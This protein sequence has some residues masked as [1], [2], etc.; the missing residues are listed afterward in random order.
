MDGRARGN[1]LVNRAAKKAVLVSITKAMIA[2]I[3]PEL[4]PIPHYSPED[5]NDQIKC[6]RLYLK[7]RWLYTSDGC[8]IL[9][10]EFAKQLVHQIHQHTYLGHRKLKELLWNAKYK[11]FYLGSLVDEVI[12]HCL[13]YKAVLSLNTG[14]GNPETA[15][16]DKGQVQTRKYDTLRSSQ[17]LNTSEFL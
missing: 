10:S 9:P 3:L 4:P 17:V 16:E 13:A 8:V 12:S 11:I 7:E 5:K 6:Q 2:L 1:R 14:Q 15:F